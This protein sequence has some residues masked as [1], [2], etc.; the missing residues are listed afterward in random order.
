MAAPPLVLVLGWLLCACI[1]L[2]DPGRGSVTCL[3]LPCV[4]C[5]AA[6][7]CMGEATRLCTTQHSTSTRRQPRL[8]RMHLSYALVKA[9]AVRTYIYRLISACVHTMSTWL[10]GT[11]HVCCGM[12]SQHGALVIQAYKAY[13]LPYHYDSHRPSPSSKQL[14][15]TEGDRHY[16]RAWTLPVTTNSQPL[17]VTTVK[18]YSIH[19]ATAAQPLL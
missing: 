3:L 6:L 19:G 5:C 2:C 11:C 9:G 7:C 13:V 15:C 16:T 8:Q 17:V 14:S 4:I 18:L 12:A 1:T 10:I